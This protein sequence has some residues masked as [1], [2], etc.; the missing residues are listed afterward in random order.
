MNNLFLYGSSILIIVS[1]VGYFLLIIFGNR[2]VTD[3][4][5]FDI[6]KDII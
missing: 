6:T 3:D 5:G 2:K 1:F 4:S